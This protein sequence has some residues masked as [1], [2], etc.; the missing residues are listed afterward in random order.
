MTNHA[1]IFCILLPLVGCSTYFENVVYKPAPATYQEWSKPGASILDIKKSLLEC[2]KPSP[3]TSFEI[4]EKAFNISR[5][6][7]MTYMNKLQLEDICMERIG[8]QY[9][10]SYSTRE[11]CLQEQYSDLPACQ[12]GAEIPT[13]TMSRRLDS[14]YCK[15]KSDYEYCLAH[16]LA[17]RLCSLE[18]VKH[19][20]PE[21]LPPG[22]EYDAA[23]PAHQMQNSDTQSY[24]PIRDFPER[25]IQLQQEVQKSS[26]RQMDKLLHDTAPKAHR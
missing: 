24:E 19:P 4:Y 3:D 1:L 14:W 7:E 20:P 5:Y 15:V 2:G 9:L 26:N 13:P 21:C 12:T 18:K 17:P 10:G 25:S 8:Y 6:D 16:A 22:R 23:L 11:I